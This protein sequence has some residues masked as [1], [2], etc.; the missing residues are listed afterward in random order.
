MVLL[1]RGERGRGLRKGSLGMEAWLRSPN[2]DSE[3][4]FEVPL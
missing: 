2:H 3:P 4:G 1:Q